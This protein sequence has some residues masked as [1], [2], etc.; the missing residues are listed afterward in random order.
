EVGL[1]PGVLNIVHGLG[2][3]VG[4]PLVQSP[5]VAAVSFTGSTATGAE[6]ASLAA[7]KFKKLSLEMGGKNPNIIFAD[8]DF[9]AALAGTLRSSFSNQGQICL[10]G[11]RVYVERSL[12]SKFRA[13]LLE[14]VAQ[15]QVGDPLVE[16]VDQGAVVSQ[17]HFQ[18][19]MSY[20][21]MAR[22]EGGTVIAGGIRV[23]LQGRCE[24]G[25]FIAPTIIEGLNSSSRVN[26]EEIFGPVITLAPFDS[27]DEVLEW[28]NS[29]RYG[30][31]ASL[32][33]SNLTRAHRFSSRL[34]AGIVWI[35]TWML[36]DLR[37]P[38]GGVK[39][40]GVGREG[41]VEVLRFFTEPK[42]VCIKLD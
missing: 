38:F 3:K 4:R 10:C 34:R 37:T 27:E 29:T 42:N 36:R 13:A 23:E 32:W 24:N 28:A 26:Q 21:E 18:K 14:K 5:Q 30:L 9:E 25:W 2:T 12:Y 22:Q 40:S 35:N 31:A 20:I 7:P 15:L 33:T 6:I 16:G 39:D 1:P 17:G 11:S 19:V 8:A 41:G